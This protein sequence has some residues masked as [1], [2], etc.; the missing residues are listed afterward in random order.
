MEM[1]NG[2][3]EMIS[4]FWRQLPPALVRESI[5]EVLKQT[6]PANAKST[7]PALFSMA[8]NNGSV[9]FPSA[10]QYQLF[11]FIPILQ[12]IDSSAAEQYLKKYNELSGKLNKYPNGAQSLWA[13]PE[14]DSAAKLTLGAGVTYSVSRN[15]PEN[16]PYMADMHK[17]QKLTAEAESGHAS[18]A[19]PKILTIGTPNLR[20]AAY[21]N[22]A[23]ATMD[24]HPEIA[25]EC[26]SK[27]LD[28]SDK[29]PLQFKLMGMR[30][31]INVYMHMNDLD[32]AKSMIEKAMSVTHEVYRED[33]NPDDPNKALKAYWPATDAYRGLL[34]Q[35]SR[36]S[37]AWA[38]TLLNDIRDPEVKVAAEVAVSGTWLG[39]PMGMSVT[40]T[41]R[42]GNFG[43]MVS[44]EEAD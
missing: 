7:P 8:S 32:N 37:P 11:Q 2:F 9:T 14:G 10:F 5:D 43:T 40:M 44:G 41:D 39:I 6:D 18:D 27:L 25:R 19:L 31:A 4:H 24:D 36:I 17:V 20:G 42:K 12:Q 26:L 15:E 33:A 28:I 29:L 13:Q 34:H 35:A 16:N 21:N 38:M 1:G 30:A 22:I 3:P 23:H